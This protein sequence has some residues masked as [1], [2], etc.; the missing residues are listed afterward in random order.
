MGQLILCTAPLAGEPYYMESASLH[1]YSLEEISY[2]L[3][4][5]VDF[6]DG[7]FMCREFCEWIQ[8]QT[9]EEELAKRLLTCIEKKASICEFAG[10]L[11]V[12]AG[13]ADRAQIERTLRILEQLEDKDELEVR[14]IRADRLMKR[15][16]YAAAAAGYRSLLQMAGADAR[17]E[18]MGN[19]C[20][21]LGTAYTGMFLFLPAAEC[22]REAYEK[23]R[24]PESL[25]GE[26]FSLLMA[27]RKAEAESRAG[28]DPL[29]AELLVSCQKELEEKRSGEQEVRENAPAEIQARVEIWKREYKE[30]GR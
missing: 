21:N 26:L 8:T 28:G 16:R 17:E 23:N 19:V 11:L 6:L 25:R 15:K 13:Y 30:Y 7:D 9:G 14:K 18:L 27:D 29:A 22:F 10:L 1:F 12:Y 24:N 4:Q 20:H 5:N 2:Y 3:I